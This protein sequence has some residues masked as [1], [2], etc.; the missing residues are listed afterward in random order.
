MLLS[1]FRISTA[2]QSNCF[3]LY[4]ILL[5]KHLIYLDVNVTLKFRYIFNLL[6]NYIF[7]KYRG[8]GRSPKVGRRDASPRILPLSMGKGAGG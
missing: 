5:Y 2:S 1:I 3:I 4:L 7:Y 6:K 8:L